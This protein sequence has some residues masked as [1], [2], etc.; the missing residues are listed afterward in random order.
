MEFCTLSLS[1]SLSFALSLSLTH[2]RIYSRTYKPTHRCTS[3]PIKC[4]CRSHIHFRACSSEAFGPAVVLEARRL[5]LLHRALGSHRDIPALSASNRHG[6]V[7]WICIIWRIWGGSVLGTVPHPIEGMQKAVPCTIF[8]RSWSSVMTTTCLTS[9]RRWK[10]DNLKPR[11][12]VA[13]ISSVFEATVGSGTASTT[14]RRGQQS[15]ASPMLQPWM[16]PLGAKSGS[17]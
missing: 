12:A 8:T 13:V 14:A 5:R 17:A 9:G 4:G 1:L 6:E 2:T 15:A 7:P 3:A 11:A 10:A 16:L